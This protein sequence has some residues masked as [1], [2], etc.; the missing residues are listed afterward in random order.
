MRLFVLVS[1]NST[2]LK[3]AKHLIKDSQTMTFFN[4]IVK[5]AFRLAVSEQHRFSV[6][7]RTGTTQ[8]VEQI[9]GLLSVNRI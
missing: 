3:M 4:L 2:F 6:T 7:K 8:F 9:I 5:F 1:A